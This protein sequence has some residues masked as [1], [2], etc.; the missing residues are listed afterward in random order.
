MLLRSNQAIEQRG[1]V[2]IWLSYLAVPPFLDIA[3]RQQAATSDK[4]LD[5]FRDKIESSITFR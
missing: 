3:L 4:K 1:I 5:P 2:L